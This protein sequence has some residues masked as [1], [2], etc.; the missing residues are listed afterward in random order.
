MKTKKPKPERRYARTTYQ[1]SKQ[2]QSCRSYS[3]PYHVMVRSDDTICR[4][5]ASCDGP[6]HTYTCED[7]PH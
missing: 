1:S 4:T 5:V 3:T 2:I 6:N 7:Y